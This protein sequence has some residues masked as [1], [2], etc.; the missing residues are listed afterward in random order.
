MVIKIELVKSSVY[1]EDKLIFLFLI[2]KYKE[3]GKADFVHGN[4]TRKPINAFDNSI[5]ENI[6][7]LYKSK[8]YDFNFN[9]FKK[10][11]DKKNIKVSYNFIYKTLTKEGIISKS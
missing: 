8:Y 5:S 11:L 1:L 10:F 9:H 2:I 6:I 3:N 7:L 4:R